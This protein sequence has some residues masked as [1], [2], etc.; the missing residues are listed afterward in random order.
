MVAR[1]RALLVAITA[2]LLALGAV[3]PTLAS[4]SS[5]ET[6][7]LTLINN[8]RVAHGERALVL[9]SALRSVAEWRSSDLITHDY[10]GHAIP[11]Y[12]C[13]EV[14]AVLSSRGISFRAWGEILAWN[15]GYGSLSATKAFE[16]WLG[17]PEHRSLILDPAF[18]SAGIGAYVGTWA[19]RTPA[20]SGDS[21]GVNAAGVHM[22]TVDFIEGSASSGSSGSGSGH[23]APK[24]TAAPAPKTAPR[25]APALVSPPSGPSG[26]V[27]R[28][29]FMAAGLLGL[30]PS[31]TAPAQTRADELAVATPATFPVPD[32]GPADRPLVALAIAAALAYGASLLLRHLRGGWRAA[33]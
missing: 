31:T 18:T 15:Y 21:S 30:D 26:R 17:S 7:L 33:S 10:F 16:W 23:T 24:P 28:E 29:R 6:Q 12:G 22:Y 32:R 3:G 19:R 14:G 1:R 2:I 20:C 5:D 25:L 4:T 27:M 13:R 9:S 8:Y 11:S